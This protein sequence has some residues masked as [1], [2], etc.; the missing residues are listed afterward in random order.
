MIR[1]VR[2]EALYLDNVLGQSVLASL[3][4]LRDEGD[5]NIVAEVGGLF[6]KHSSDKVKAILVAAEKGDAKALHL[7]AHCQKFS[8][9]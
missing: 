4:E 5:L 7:A 3:R 2:Y 1:E 6:L 8:S 9:A